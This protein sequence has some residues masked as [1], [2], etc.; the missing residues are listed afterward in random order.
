[1]KIIFEI[2]TIVSYYVNIVKE[3]IVYVYVGKH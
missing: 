2:K 3:F 1:M